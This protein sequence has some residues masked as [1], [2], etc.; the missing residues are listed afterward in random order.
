MGVAVD[1]EIVDAPGCATAMCGDL[2]HLLIT[3][4]VGI[5]F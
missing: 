3:I 2:F 1:Q 5:Y 4:M